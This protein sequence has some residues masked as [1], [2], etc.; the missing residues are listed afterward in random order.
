MM[1]KLGQDFTFLTVIWID[2]YFVPRPKLREIDTHETF[3]RR[4]KHYNRIRLRIPR[5][6][7]MINPI[8]YTNQD[9]FR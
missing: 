8:E 5:A 7:E 1:K 3:V 4:G 9:L 6:F 2:L